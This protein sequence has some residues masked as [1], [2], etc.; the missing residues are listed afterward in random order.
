MLDLVKIANVL[1]AAADH[2]DAIE[3]EKVSSV[4]A[5]RHAQI[6]TLAS[7][8]AEATG[9]EMPDSIRQKLAS[10]DKDV[11]SLINAMVEKQAGRVESLGGPS[12]K[13]DPAAP[14]SVKE[15]AEAADD[16]FLKWICS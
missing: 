4:Q 3:S 12:D 7:K 2:L 13:E 10:S 9:E 11:V 5:E 8:Y 15:A 14:T 16:A 6:D 1:D